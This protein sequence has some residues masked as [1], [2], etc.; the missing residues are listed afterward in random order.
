MA[1][2]NQKTK[3]LIGVAVSVVAKCQPCLE[4]HVAEAR[5]AGACDEEMNVAIRLAQAVHR[6]GDEQMAKF[7]SKTLGE[8]PEGEGACDCPCSCG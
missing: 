5:K 2:M 7:V 8:I 6:A 3:E 1:I 4:Y